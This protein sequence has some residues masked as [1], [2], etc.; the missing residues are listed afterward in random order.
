MKKFK[1]LFKLI[2][3][4]LVNNIFFIL[5]GKIYL[6]KNNNVKIKEINNSKIKKI[7]QKNYKIYIIKNG[8]V[9]TDGVEQVAYITGNSL[10]KN[11]SYTQIKGTLVSAN[12]NFVLKRGT[13]YFKKKIDG[14]VLSLAQGASGN[15]NYFHWMFDILPKI[16]IVLSYFSIKEIDY[17]YMPALQNFQIRILNILGVKKFK[18]IDSN[19][20][21]HIQATK[22]IVPEHPWYNKNKIFDQVDKLPTWIVKWLRSS[23]L[24]KGKSNSKNKNFFIDRSETKN[25]HCQLINNDQIKKILLKKGFK[26]IK[27]G[28]YNFVNQITLFSNADIIIGPHGA[29]FTNL[30]F[31]KPNTK[32][33]EIKPINRPNNYKTISKIN[34][35]KYKQ[36]ITSLIPV[37]KR[38]NGDMYLNP[39][40]LKNLLSND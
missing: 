9:C 27:V 3:K 21:K 28:K 4:T 6:A 39:K 19:K 35:L 30:I 14:I 20:F 23:F 34:N 15:K 8:R 5:Y 40:K 2:Y 26:A 7:N 25:K 29:A 18:I 38:I 1:N 16:K 17:F 12:K 22:I 36:I 10:I 31:C 37:K 13:P 32:V 11:I 33:I 24:E